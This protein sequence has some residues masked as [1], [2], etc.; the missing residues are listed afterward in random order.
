LG[1]AVEPK[2]TPFVDDSWNADLDVLR[3]MTQNTIRQSEKPVTRAFIPSS[4]EAVAIQK[5][6]L[7]H[8]QFR[9]FDAYVQQLGKPYKKSNRELS[10]FLVQD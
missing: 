4:S 3:A 9:A 10:T 5:S 7:E 8:D 1:Q 2:V 6:V